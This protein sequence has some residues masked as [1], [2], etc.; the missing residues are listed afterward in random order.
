MFFRSDLNFLLLLDK[1][2]SQ[3]TKY[4]TQY[5]SLA[6]CRELS[7]LTWNINLF[8]FTYW[9]CL[10]LS[11]RYILSLIML[12][13]QFIRSVHLSLC[14]VDY[15]VI[16]TKHVCIIFLIQSRKKSY[17]C[18][19]YITLKF[20]YVL[21]SYENLLSKKISLSILKFKINRDVWDKSIDLNH[22]FRI[23]F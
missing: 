23:Y 15:T 10:L 16:V 13:R 2:K 11:S 5:T 8:A 14:C 21:I 22:N 19:V 12:L 7:D 4:E 6:H 18:I 9:T 1:F 3:R 17:A 20:L